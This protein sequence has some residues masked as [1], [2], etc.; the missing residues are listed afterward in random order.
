MGHDSAGSMQND[1]AVAEVEPSETGRHP[2]RVDVFTLFPG[3][4]DGP[5]SESI[6]RRARER[7][8]IEIVVHDIRTW[9]PDRHRTADDTPYGGGA[10]MVLKA[11]P[12]VEAVEDVLGADHEQAWIVLLSA[13]GRQFTQSVARELSVACRIAL[14]CGRYDGVQHGAQPKLQPDERD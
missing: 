2:L 1:Q 14:T 9:T 6:L 5:L 4:F 12:I 13:S 7:G 11:P 3:M 10:G 8:L